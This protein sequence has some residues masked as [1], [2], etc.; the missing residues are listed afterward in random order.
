[1]TDNNPTDTDHDTHKTE[2][3][4]TPLDT[5]HSATVVTESRRYDGYVELYAHHVRVVCNKDGP[6]RESA[7]WLP[8]ATVMQVRDN[9]T[10]H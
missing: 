5:I 9:T 1:M 3:Y 8:N 10:Q 2:R 4:D 7:R 6:F